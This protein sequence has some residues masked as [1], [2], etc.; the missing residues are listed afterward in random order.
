MKTWA[1]IVLSVL[2]ALVICICIMFY[3]FY[4][5][6][7]TIWTYSTY[8]MDAVRDQLSE[9]VWWVISNFDGKEGW[10]YKY[11]WS[12]Q[13]EWEVYQYACSVKWKDDVN[14]EL[15]NLGPVEAQSGDV[16]DGM[17]TFDLES[18]QWRLE[19]C[20]ERVGYTLNY[21]EWDFTWWDESEAWWA[22]VRTGHVNYIKWWEKAEDDVN[23]L[24]DM[25]SKTVTVDFSNHVYNWE[26]SEESWDVA[27][28]AESGSV[29][30]SDM[31]WDETL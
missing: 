4:R 19:A 16:V 18:E 11:S 21:N 24:V 6:V 20:E 25:V 27:N 10:V 30:A 9:N 8:C 2:C 31:T 29:E 17:P 26:I 3:S 15:N 1:K 28:S 14:L 12:V 13:Y 7:K 5:E 22:F 23:C